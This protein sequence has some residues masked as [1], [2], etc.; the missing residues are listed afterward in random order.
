MRLKNQL[1]KIRSGASTL[2]KWYN[3]YK[4]IY[5]LL[6]YSMKKEVQQL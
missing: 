5:Y 1:F 4:D 6:K 3:I 2:Q